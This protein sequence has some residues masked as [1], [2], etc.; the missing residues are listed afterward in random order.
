MV[1][2]ALCGFELALAPIAREDCREALARML[3]ALSS[4][5]LT[6]CMIAELADRYTE[7]RFSRCG[8]AFLAEAIIV[9]GYIEVESRL[10]RVM[11]VMEIR[12]SARP[13]QLRPFHIDDIDITIGQPLTARHGLS[14]GS[15]TRSHPATAF[16]R[17]QTMADRDRPRSLP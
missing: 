7:L 10:Q 13:R 9:H 6:V 17:D 8:T 1:I 16:A 15:L 11:A 5:G 2:D 12:A 3:S 14:G 4:L